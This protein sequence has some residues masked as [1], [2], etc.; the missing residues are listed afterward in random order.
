MQSKVAGV[1]FICGLVFWF[2]VFLMSGHCCFWPTINAMIW[3]DWKCRILIRYLF[4]FHGFV[5]LWRYLSKI[6]TI[7]WW[8][9]RI[10]RLHLI[11]NKLQTFSISLFVSMV[12]CDRKRTRKWKLEIFGGIGW[13]LIKCGKKLFGKLNDDMFSYGQDMHQGLHVFGGV[14]FGV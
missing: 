12:G 13:D 2:C 3:C 5:V 9:P 11:E 8:S 1:A 7:I 10:H 4:V 14:F 6:S